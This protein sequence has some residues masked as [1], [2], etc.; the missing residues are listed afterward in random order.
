M[1]PVRKQHKPT[2]FAEQRRCRDLFDRGLVVA[3]GDVPGAA[4]G[5]RF[6]VTPA[7]T[8]QRVGEVAKTVDWVSV[9][10]T[11][12]GL[13]KG[14]AEIVGDETDALSADEN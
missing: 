4:G 8:L 1:A 2:L 6:E 14:I 7:Q 9:S 10:S 5:T 3:C 11:I 12:N 13:N